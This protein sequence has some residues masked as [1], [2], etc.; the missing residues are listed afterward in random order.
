MNK[1]ALPTFERIALALIACGMAVIFTTGF[2]HAGFTGA[3]LWSAS[4]SFAA[5]SWQYIYFM[6]LRKGE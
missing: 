3:L 6:A 1:N 4:T 5:L 2:M